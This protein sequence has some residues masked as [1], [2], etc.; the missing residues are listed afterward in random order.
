MPNGGIASIN[1]YDVLP[2]KN[3]SKS[4]IPKPYW[5]QNGPDFDY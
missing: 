1:L 5:E 4:S 2:A 3:D